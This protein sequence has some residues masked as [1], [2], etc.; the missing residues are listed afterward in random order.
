MTPRAQQAAYVLAL[1]AALAALAFDIAHSS[2]DMHRGQSV[3]V[4]H[5]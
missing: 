5:A 1:L 3:N 2:P 4:G